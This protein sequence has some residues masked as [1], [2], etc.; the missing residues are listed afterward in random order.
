MKSRLQVEPGKSEH[1][2]KTTTEERPTTLAPG[3]VVKAF[4]DA[5]AAARMER[6]N[7]MVRTVQQVDES[8]WWI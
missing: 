1:I 4:D 6:V 2:P 7:F 3:A 8:G 5:R